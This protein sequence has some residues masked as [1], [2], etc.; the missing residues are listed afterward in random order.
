MKRSISWGFEVR[1]KSTDVS[2]EHVA[3]IF[4]AEEEAEHSSACHLISRWF[5]ALLILRPWRWRRYVVP[6]S[7]LT[8]S[9]LHGVI[10]QETES[11][12]NLTF[13]WTWS[14]SN[15]VINN[16]DIWRENGKVKSTLMASSFMCHNSKGKF[17]FEWNLF[18]VCCPPTLD[19][20]LLDSL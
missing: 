16:S 1:W 11:V 2:E 3:Y 14:I 9:G 7:R 18:N 12:N 17:V 13:L 20:S 8:F 5:L 19:L 15:I 6:K 4:R 10:S